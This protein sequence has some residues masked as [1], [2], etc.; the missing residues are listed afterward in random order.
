M[1][2]AG[3]LA[4]KAQCPSDGHGCKSCNHACI[5][6]AITG[7]TTVLVNGRPALIVTSEGIHSSC[8][9]PNKWV[10]N[11]GSATVMINNQPVHRMGDMTQHCGGVGKLIEG[12]TNV[13]VGGAPGPPA[14][15]PPPE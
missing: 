7:S 11:Q 13:I 9:G 8:C 3:R 10:A 6:P 15:L 12:S 1:P 14:G 2:G 4:D 5:G